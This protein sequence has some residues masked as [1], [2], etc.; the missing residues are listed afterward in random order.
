MSLLKKVAAAVPFPSKGTKA[1]IICWLINVQELE[2][3]SLLREIRR[4]QALTLSL[5]VTFITYLVT[6]KL[7]WGTLWGSP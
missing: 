5:V 3:A 1:D 7:V 6:G 4:W 2:K